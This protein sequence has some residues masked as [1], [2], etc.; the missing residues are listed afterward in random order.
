MSSDATYYAEIWLR[1]V[2]IVKLGIKYPGSTY[3]YYGDEVIINTDEWTPFS[4]FRQPTN[5]GG[6]GGIKLNIKYDDERGVPVDS[7]L[8]IGAAWL[9]EAPPPDDWPL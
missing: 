7:K 5:D 3:V 2:G 1:G 4:V 6:D 8:F 9:G